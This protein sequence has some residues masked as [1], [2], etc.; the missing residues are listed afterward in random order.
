MN[1]GHWLAAP[2]SPELF[3]SPKILMRRTDDHLLACLEADSS[4]CVN[5]CHV[6]KLN[7]SGS[8]EIRFEYLLGLLNSSL[9]QRVFEVQNPQ[10]VGKVFAEIKIIYVERLPIRAINFTDK[11][12]K[13]AQDRMVS[14][15]EAMLDL[16]KK[17]AAAKTPQEKT[18]LERQ[19]AAAD[20]EIDRLVYELYGLTEDEIKIVEGTATAEPAPVSEAVEAPEPAAKPKR[21]SRKKSAFAAPPQAPAD[22]SLTPEKAYNDAAH[23]YGKEEPPPYPAKDHED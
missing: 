1:Y 19:I 10:M 7:E 18:V 4:I 8:A 5:S 3:S 22:A 15:V 23:F 12:D 14:L 13:A 21:A 2:R 16:H 17:L 11:S 9:I 20:A 6:I